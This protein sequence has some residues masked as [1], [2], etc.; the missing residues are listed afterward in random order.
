MFSTSVPIRSGTDG[1][2]GGA[3]GALLDASGQAEQVPCRRDPDLWFAET[4]AELER[5][6]GLCADCPIKQPCLEG[7]LSRGEP[8]G[9]WGGEIFE[10]GAVVARKRPRG[11][12]R[13]NAAEPAQQSVPEQHSSR[14]RTADQQAAP[15]T[16]GAKRDEQ[17]Q[18]A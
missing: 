7:A 12:P 11:R 14:N 5:A 9:V 15:G 13:K 3:V 8:W 16:S 17:E 10:R 1:E 2:G 18:A 4:P 6:K